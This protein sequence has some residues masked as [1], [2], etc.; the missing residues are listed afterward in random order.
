[1]RIVNLRFNLNGNFQ[2]QNIKAP[3]LLRA[4]SKFYGSE[5]LNNIR[6]ETTCTLSR[7]RYPVTCHN[8]NF[9]GQVTMIRQ[10]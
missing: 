1:M 5:G 6:F 10:L 3:S 9:R 4:L 8:A 2:K 7:R